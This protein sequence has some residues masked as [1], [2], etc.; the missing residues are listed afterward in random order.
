[1]F[2]IATRPTPATQASP[3]LANTPFDWRLTAP[4]PPQAM[5][6]TNHA[7]PSGE[8]ETYSQM[9]TVY[10][11]ACEDILATAV[12]ISLFTDRRAGDDDVLPYNSQDRKG[13]LGDSYMQNDFDSRTDAWG[14]LL[15]LVY[16]SK[17][18]VNILER[19][20]FAAQE[21]LAWMVRDG[22]ASLV[23]VTAEWVGDVLAVRPA[24][25]QSTSPNPIYDVLWATS[26]KRNMGSA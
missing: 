13:W 3:M 18:T 16:V 20:R 25:Y 1:M 9:L 7:T 17:N 8:P 21:A 15:W 23:T 6:W 4:Q 10:A 12:I 19:A 14:S 26:I 24:I 2:D 5:P 11:L 22:L